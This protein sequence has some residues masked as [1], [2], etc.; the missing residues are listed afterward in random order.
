MKKNF[1]TERKFI[2]FYFK[3]EKHKIFEKLKIFYQTLSLIW[4]WN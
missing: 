4:S 1:F 3:M 2:S